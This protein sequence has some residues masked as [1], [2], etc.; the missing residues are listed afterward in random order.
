MKKLLMIV[1]ACYGLHAG[2]QVRQNTNFLYL[3][4]DSVI[5]ANSIR[6]RPD[7]SNE[8]QLRVDQKRYPIQQVKFFNNDQG[9]FANTRKFNDYGISEFSERIIEGK[10]NVFREV[11]YDPYVYERGYSHRN[12][13]SDI[14]DVRM[15]YN[16]GFGDLKKANYSNLS[17]DMADKAESMDLLHAY[18]RKKNTSTILYVAAGASLVASLVSFVA[19]GKRDVPHLVYHGS[20]PGPATIQNPRTNFAASF[21]LMGAGVGLAAG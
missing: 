2:A 7:F 8:L 21:G 13:R 10:I 1:M 17:Q 4:S 3:Y 15:F 12:R 19:I 5:Y 11:S 18:R 16:K 14:V 9:F 6:L 20:Y